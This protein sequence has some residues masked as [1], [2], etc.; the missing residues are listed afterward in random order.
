MLRRKFYIIKHL[1]HSGSL[2]FTG[3]MDIGARGVLSIQ[4]EKTCLAA[5]TDLQAPAREN[6]FL[7]KISLNHGTSL[8]N[9]SIPNTIAI[10]KSLTSKLPCSC[11]HIMA[12]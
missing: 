11:L 4:S 6:S 1:D 3:S 7:L 10:K 2:D 8:E 9:Q 5:V 12:N